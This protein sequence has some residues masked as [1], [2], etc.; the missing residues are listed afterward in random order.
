MGSEIFTPFKYL[1]L[2]P[3]SLRAGSL[4]RQGRW[5][6]NR[7]LRLRLHRP[8][9]SSEPA[10]RLVPLF[11]KLFSKLSPSFCFLK[12]HVPLFPKMFCNCF[13]VPQFK[14]A[15]FGFFPKTPGDL[16]QR[17][18]YFSSSIF[19]TSPAVQHHL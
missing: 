6:R 3:Y 2:F 14:L 17:R 9:L 12:F 11:L 13:P 18:F 8:C 4:D 19:Q 7:E 16:S 10:R 15:A 1:L 5:S